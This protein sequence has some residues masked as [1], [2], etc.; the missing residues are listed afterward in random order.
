[1]PAAERNCTELADVEMRWTWSYLVGIQFF[2][3]FHCPVKIGQ[4]ILLW[5][6]VFKTS[7]FQGANTSAML[8]PFVFPDVLVDSPIV[9]PVGPHIE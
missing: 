1:M 8:I 3:E 9:L 5:G 7:S 4:D 6:V 2:E